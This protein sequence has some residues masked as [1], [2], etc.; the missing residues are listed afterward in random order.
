VLSNG[1]ITIILGMLV[2]FGWPRD[3]F[4]TIGTLAGISVL[5]TGVSRLMLAL[6]AHS[7]PLNNLPDA[8]I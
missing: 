3:A 1:I 7:A 4:W 2:W 6:H 5:S 8:S